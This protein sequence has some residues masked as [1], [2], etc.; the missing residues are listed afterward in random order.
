MREAGRATLKS[1]E[2]V[3]A[4][5]VRGAAPAAGPA[6]ASGFV[7]V[8]LPLSGC[9]L[10]PLQSGTRSLK[11][12]TT[13][14]MAAPCPLLGDGITDDTLLHIA[15]FLPTTRDLLCL[16]LSCPRFAAKI[17]AVPCPAARA[18]EGVPWQRQRRRGCPS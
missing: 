9:P 18:Q 10:Y 1:G 17:I 12:S 7:G 4:M 11:R 15:H 5:T 8:T 14:T 13:P 6:A 16:Q 3:A 2:G